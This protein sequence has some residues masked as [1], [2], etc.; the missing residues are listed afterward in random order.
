MRSLGF[1]LV[2][3]LTCS[4]LF[5][6]E[7]PKQQVQQMVGSVLEV[8]NGSAALETKKV[9]VS[10]LVQKHLGIRS[11]AQRT[12]GVFWKKASPEEISRF[13]S[14]YV[15]ILEKTYLNRIGDYS[16][17]RVDYLQERIQGDKAILD[18][19]FVTDKVQI[20]VQYK[21]ILQNGIWQ[22]YDVTIEGVSLISN[23]RSSYGEIIRRDGFAGLFMLM[24]KKLA[25]AD[26]PSGK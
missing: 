19:Q 1:L 13:E 24:E 15:Q 10:G 16:G 9:Q 23:Y 25:E 12:L 26:T 2:L 21:M 17:G 22:I 18:T 14:L 7:S 3:L 6:Q 20:P 5:A 8:L 4:T 11:L